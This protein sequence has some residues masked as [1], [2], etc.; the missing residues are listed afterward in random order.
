MTEATAVLRRED[1]ALLDQSTRMHLSRAS[2]NE[3][4]QARHEF[5][6]R[7]DGLRRAF[8][9]GQTEAYVRP[10]SHFKVDGE[11]SVIQ[12]LQEGGTIYTA[13]RK[14]GYQLPYSD[15]D[16]I[17]RKVEHGI[18]AA[19]ALFGYRLLEMHGAIKAE[20]IFRY[21]DDVV[22]AG[23]AN[24][25][26]NRHEAILREAEK[27]FAFDEQLSHDAILKDEMGGDFVDYDNSDYA[28]TLRMRSLDSPVAVERLN[29]ICE[30]AL[31]RGREE[32]Q[33]RLASKY[34][35]SSPVYQ[36]HAVI[37]KVISGYD[38]M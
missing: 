16:R 37:A 35:E 13:D 10:P 20:D 15:L 23:E 25:G 34:G 38:V 14:V 32:E 2:L 21:I 5:Q 30:I 17:G 29:G 24:T 1:P 19:T 3:S 31:A 22:L 27:L 26:D 7:V 28:F 11:G 33:A 18:R 8:E 12:V 6:S 4:L 9:S 36:A